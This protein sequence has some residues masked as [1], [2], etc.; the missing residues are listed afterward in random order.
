[1]FTQATRRTQTVELGPRLE[2]TAPDFVIRDHQGKSWSRPSLMGERGLIL[3]FID[4]VWQSV[5][6]RRIIWLERHAMALVRE[7]V[8][9]A[10]I[11]GDQPHMLYGFYVSSPTPPAFPLLSDSDN[12]VHRLFSMSTIP[13]MIVI[14][15]SG[16]VR[17][18]WLMPDDRVWPS[19]RELLDVV[20]DV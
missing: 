11:S 15:R 3:G 5:S 20:G 9:L 19:V 13:G 8:N 10:L 2:S 6:V 16:T 7:G 1:M 18:K 4:D 14:D 12:K 17:H